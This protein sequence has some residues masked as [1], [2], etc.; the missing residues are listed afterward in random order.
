MALRRLF[1]TSSDESEPGAKRAKCCYAPFSVVE[2]A[3]PPA[4]LLGSGSGASALAAHL[5]SGS[6]ASAPA[7]PHLGGGNGASA[8]ASSVDGMRRL[9]P[10]SSDES[11]H[12]AKSAQRARSSGQKAA[13]TSASASSESSLGG[14]TGVSAFAA[15]EATPVGSG[16]GASAPAASGSVDMHWCSFQRAYFEK[17]FNNLG[18]QKKPL[19][20]HTLFSGMGSPTQV[21]REAGVEVNEGMMAEMKSCAHQFCSRNG[22]MPACYFEDV[23]S[24]VKRGNGQC[25][26][27][28]G[29]CRLPSARADLFVAGF[30][31]TAYSLQRVGAHN[32]ADVREHKD[33]QKMSW[34]VDHILQN[35]PR[36]F[37]LENVPAFVGVR[38]NRHVVVSAD[39]GLV[40]P[41]SPFVDMLPR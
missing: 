26:V 16:S 14:C 41:E 19:Q 11:E 36:A 9:F 37:L 34:T 5:G 32:Q 20:M 24:L 23:D 29:L 3:A 22:L 10:T 25:H 39:P 27:H 1:P 13:A 40:R 4:P 8:V 28:G 33:F 30:P 38:S 17:D 15:K 7:A 6:G 35:K 12:T 2:V 21:L 31:C 18:P